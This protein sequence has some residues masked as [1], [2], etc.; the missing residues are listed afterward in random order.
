MLQYKKGW[1]KNLQ[2]WQ[3]HVQPHLRGEKM[4]AIT[5]DDVHFVIKRMRLKI[6][7]APAT[8]KHVI[9]LINRVYN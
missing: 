8:I 5:A 7:Y 3:I 2:R 4:D 9:V 6:N 1:N